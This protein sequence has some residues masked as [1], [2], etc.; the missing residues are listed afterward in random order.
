MCRI[1]VVKGSIDE[2][3]MKR[4]PPCVAIV[5]RV[6][7]KDSQEYRRYCRMSTIFVNCDIFD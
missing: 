2:A 4:T 6:C 1:T 5:G 7:Y 3:G